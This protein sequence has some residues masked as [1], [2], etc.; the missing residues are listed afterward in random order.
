M[1]VVYCHGV[2]TLA[3]V[4]RPGWVECC[5]GCGHQFAAVTEIG[6]RLA[7]E[8]GVALAVGDDQRCS[9]GTASPDRPVS[10]GEPPVGSERR[11][12]RSPAGVTV[13]RRL[14]L[15]GGAA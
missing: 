7:P 5:C 11:S 4:I 2:K 1:I 13:L 14:R 3:R 8:A 6:R 10:S 15:V 9:T 12:Q